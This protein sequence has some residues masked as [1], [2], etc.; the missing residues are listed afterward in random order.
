M[1]VE[2]LVLGP[3]DGIVKQGIVMQIGKAIG[4]LGDAIP[5]R[6]RAVDAREDSRNAEAR[7]FPKLLGEQ[8]SA[9]WRYLGHA[10]LIE[11]GDLWKRFT[12]KS[13]RDVVDA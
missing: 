12:G 3:F 7:Q 2:N 11:N 8:P 4:P 6:R 5:L 1:A 13:P 10:T 9:G